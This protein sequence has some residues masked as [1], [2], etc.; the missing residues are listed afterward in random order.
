MADVPVAG[1]VSDDVTS[2]DRGFRCIFCTCI[3]YTV[4]AT[5]GGTCTPAGAAES[6][7]LS[8]KY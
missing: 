7:R 2:S 8:I 3:N 1:D 6:A 4:G 5:S